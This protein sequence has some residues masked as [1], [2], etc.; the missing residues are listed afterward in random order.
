MTPSNRALLRFPHSPTT[1]F[2]CNG[3]LPLIITHNIHQREHPLPTLLIPS[4]SSKPSSSRQPTNQTNAR[5][6]T[7]NPLH[8]LPPPPRR[9]RRRHDPLLLL[10]LLKTIRQRQLILIVAAESRQSGGRRTDCEYVPADWEEGDHV[11]FA[12]EW[13]QFGR[14]YGEDTE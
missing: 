12:E 3:T 4:S 8:P 13:G 2:P 5:P 6:T 9:L 1:L 11:G 14:Y 7:P 10:P